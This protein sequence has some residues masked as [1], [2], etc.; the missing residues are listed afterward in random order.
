M[1]GRVIA[2]ILAGLIAAGCGGGSSGT[3]TA[4]TTPPTPTGTPAPAVEELQDMLLA[5]FDRLGIDPEKVI[6]AAPSGD[7]NAVFDLQAEVV[8]PDGDGPLTPTGIE[9]TWTERLTGDYD[10]NGMVGVSDLTPIGQRWDS[11]VDYDDP[12]S[13]DGI[14]YW[15]TGDPVD[16]GSANWRLARVDGNDN[17]LIDVSDITPIAQ[18]WEE[19]LSGYRVYRKAP[20][21]DEFELLYDPDDLYSNM[22]VVRPA[23]VDQTGLVRYSF[24]DPAPWAGDYEYYVIGWSELTGHSSSEAETESNHAKATM[25]V[26]TA[27]TTPPTWDT[28]IGAI[29]ASA[30][31]DGTV[32]IEWGTATDIA[33][34]PAPASPPVTYNLYYST[35]S[36]I[37]FASATR[38]DGLSTTSWTSGKLVAEQEYFFAIRAQDSADPPNEDLNEAERSVTVTDTEPVEDLDPPVW[39]ETYDV[40]NELGEVL[41]SETVKGIKKMKVGDGVIT[42]TCADAV[43]ELSPPVHYDLY[44]VSDRVSDELY[45]SNPL[46]PVPE[47]QVIQD[48]PKVFEFEWENRHRVHMGVI[49]RDSAQAANVTRPLGNFKQLST[50]PSNLVKIPLDMDIPLVDEYWS[51]LN[52]VHQ[53]EYSSCFDV[54]THTLYIFYGYGFWDDY[55]SNPQELWV[56]EID[57]DTGEWISVHLGTWD[58]ATY[59]RIHLSPLG[60]AISPDGT[61]WLMASLSDMGKYTTYFFHRTGPQQYSTWE[62]PD[63]QGGWSKDFS[64]N[65]YPAYYVTEKSDVNPNGQFKLYYRWWDESLG[66]W[67]QEFVC[68]PSGISPTSFVRPDRVVQLITY[69]DLSMGAPEVQRYGHIHERATDGTWTEVLRTEG[70]LDVPNLGIQ[71]W[72]SEWAWTGSAWWGLPA[73]GDRDMLVYS[74]SQGYFW[75]EDLYLN[76]YGIQTYGNWPADGGYHSA[77]SYLFDGTGPVTKSWGHYEYSFLD[78]STSTPYKLVPSPMTNAIC[79]DLETGWYGTLTATVDYS[80]KATQVNLW[81]ASD[82]Q[83][84]YDLEN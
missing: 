3:I 39:T 25:S 36:P 81:T 4:G 20:G 52:E 1:A 68:D 12:S 83:S 17:G 8:D 19:K 59:G 62:P 71:Y 40:M 30:N 18:H 73:T 33:L 26:S 7:K 31:G 74:P 63:V 84:L 78:A 80:D 27:D 77:P 24:S 51:R 61:P 14:V 50:A 9:L 10:M 72:D 56:L 82:G 43:D 11:V 79:Y 64:F 67:H 21:A 57:M 37:D 13:H 55:T 70:R 15:P 34:P 5:E 66:E 47:A 48:I 75:I 22:T 42:I 49:A 54:H 16:G 41:G 69:D 58:Y 65:D 60:T 35:V 46:R 53:V 38:V 2:L 23:S 29:T 45:L 28:T 76:P 6:A 44:Y 32:T